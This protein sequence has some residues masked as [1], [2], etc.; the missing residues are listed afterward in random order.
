MCLNRKDNEFNSKL[1]IK[2]RIWITLEKN[3]IKLEK[4]GTRFETLVYE[5]DSK[6]ENLSGFKQGIER[7]L[8]QIKFGHYFFFF[9]M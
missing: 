6:L 9:F 8:E 1:T 7:V 5:T 2:D 3:I 4:G